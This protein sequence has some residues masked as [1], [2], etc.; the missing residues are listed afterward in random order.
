MSGQGKDPASPTEIGWQLG[1]SSVV[2]ESRSGSWGGDKIAEGP[3]F[4]LHSSASLTSMSWSAQWA[5]T[6]HLDERPKL[7]F[8]AFLTETRLR[9]LK[10]D[11]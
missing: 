1:S 2:L 3:C 11:L 8:Q 7:R 10:N 5:K 4:R 6:T 9:F